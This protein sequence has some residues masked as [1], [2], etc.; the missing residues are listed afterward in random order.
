MMF[1]HRNARPGTYQGTPPDE[2]HAQVA[3]QSATANQSET[4]F[5]TYMTLDLVRAVINCKLVGFQ[6][7]TAPVIEFQRQRFVA[8]SS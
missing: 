4:W 3:N 8:T 6:L 7:A 5:P 1:L 2:E